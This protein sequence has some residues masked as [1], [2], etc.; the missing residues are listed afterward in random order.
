M[1]PFTVRLFAD[2]WIFGG[3]FEAHDHVLT[4]APASVVRAE[5]RIAQAIRLHRLVFKMQQLQRHM[6]AAFMFA[7]HLE[8]V[9]F[10]S[11]RSEFFFGPREHPRLEGRVVDVVG[12]R[13]AQAGALC[14]FEVA[15]H[16]RGAD[17]ALGNLSQAES[18]R[19]QPQDVGDL[20]HG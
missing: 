8:P 17:A 13:S 1:A 7:V 11:S 10:L 16:R 5:L 6:L 2:G 14:A 9:G 15:L 3:A 18:L 20:A 12:Q 19:A 4:R